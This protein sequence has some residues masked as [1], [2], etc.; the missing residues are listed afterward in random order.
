VNS[1]EFPGAL[2]LGLLAAL[3]AHT[4]I[5]GG[6]HAM[7]GAYHALLLQVA[8]CGGLSLLVFFAALAL[9][10]S[11]G[12]ADGSIV[13]ERLRERLPGIAAVLVAAAAWYAI[14]EGIE[15]HHAG[16]SPLF[17]LLVLAAV[18]W[19]VLRFAGAAVRALAAVVLTIL[20]L[21]F[22]PRAP[23]WTRRSA[24]RPFLRRPLFTR[25]RFARPPPTAA[26]SR[27]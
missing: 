5:F 23:S 17:A 16:P 1:R 8:L 26:A 25:R 4:A 10:E 18:S 24:H 27:A 11:G 19:I 13:A 12:A 6:D 2:I 7:G 22:A 20:G 21:S 3:V 14:A 15:P 9:G